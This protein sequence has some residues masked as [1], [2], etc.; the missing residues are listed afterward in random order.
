[1]NAFVLS[2]ALV[3]LG[4][5]ALPH[6][7][8]RP[9]PAII[10]TAAAREALRATYPKVVWHPVLRVD[11]DCDGADDRIF[12]GRHA[13]RFYVAAVL[14]GRSRMPKI[15]VTRFL[16]QGTSQDSFCGPP[17]VL[18]K[19]SMDYYPEDSSAMAPEGFRRSSNCHGLRLEAGECDSFHFFWNHAANELDWWRL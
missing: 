8:N 5:T 15:S 10:T 12:T 3:L 2:A 4:P 14:T 18:A 9:A 19:E 11:I 6:D 7:G 13:G 16:L 17:S 1:M